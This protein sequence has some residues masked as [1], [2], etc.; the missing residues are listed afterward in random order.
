[1]DWGSILSRVIGTGY[2]GVS[3]GDIGTL[4]DIT[5]KVSSYKDILTISTYQ[6]D[7]KARTS[8]HEIIGQRPILEFLGPDLQTISFSIQLRAW[9]GANPKQALNTLR[10]YCETG[11][12]LQ[13]SMGG[14]PVGENKWLIESISGTA[15]YFDGSGNIVS[16]DASV[17]LKEYVENKG[18]GWK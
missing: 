3:S 18:G 14:S 12:V 17:S 10:R 9:C 8:T 4:G 5:F 11:E 16:A 2:A 13:F 1:M 15:N 7:A 6:R